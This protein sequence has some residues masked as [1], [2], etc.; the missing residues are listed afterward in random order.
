[1]YNEI[2]VRV[3]WG[4]VPRAVH[5]ELA[6]GDIGCAARFYEG[7]SGWKAER[8]EGQEDF[9]L[10]STGQRPTAKASWLPVPTDCEHHRCAVGGDVYQKNRL[11]PAG[12]RSCRRCPF[13]AWGTLHTTGT[14]KATSS[15]SCTAAWPQSRRGLQG[16]R[17][18]TQRRNRL[19]PLLRYHI[20]TAF[21]ALY[22]HLVVDEFAD[23]KEEISAAKPGQ[24]RKRAKGHRT[25]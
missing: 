24:F 16:G 21:V 23:V 4:H 6:A 11:I 20:V 13:P 5:F 18:V 22:D 7:V 25:C 8:W 15:E 2:I 1:M 14:R 10:V 12:R 3:Q 17:K 9:M 19:V